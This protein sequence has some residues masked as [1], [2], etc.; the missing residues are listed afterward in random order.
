V[1]LLLRAN[2]MPPATKHS[3]MLSH[4]TMAV[5]MTVALEFRSCPKQ[6]KGRRGERSRRRGPPGGGSWLVE[7]RQ[8]TRERLARGR[9]RRRC[10]SVCR[11]VCLGRRVGGGENVCVEAVVVAM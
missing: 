11:I 7:H 2:L 9:R 3:S 4:V 5:A 8:D 10:L 6:T 1:C